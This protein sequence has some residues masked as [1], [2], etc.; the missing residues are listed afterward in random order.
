M[1]IYGNGQPGKGTTTG[2]DYPAYMPS[3]VVV[4]P[5]ASSSSSSG[6]SSLERIIN[7]G[8]PITG[9]NSGMSVNANAA[10]LS[11]LSGIASQ[12]F[13][14]NGLFDLIRENTNANNAWS[15]AQAQKQMD[16][17]TQANQIAME[18]NSL[19]A[20]KNRDW[21]KMMSDTA[22]QREIA[23]L[24]AAG[25][26]PVLSA[27]NG[28]GASTGSGATASGVTSAGAQADADQSAN[29]AM[30][31]IY[32]SIINAQTS[33]YNANLSAQTNLRMAEMQQQASM[34]G[35]Q[36]AAAASNYAA[37]QNY[38]AQ[39][40]G[41]DQSLLNQREQRDWNAQHPNSMWQTV[42]SDP[43]TKGAST[44]FDWASGLINSAKQ[45]IQKS[46]S[47]HG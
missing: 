26:N 20:A 44:V 14:F 3:S 7:S 28:N 21:Q 41:A 1:S 40:Y 11:G 6:S 19:E 31:A 29:T 32:G 43:V 10:N 47:T 45:K 37:G 17:Q 27:M 38:A 42:A 33:M 25:L 18:F 22:H 34:Y 5:S 46:S 12:G 36:M 15:A 35:A 23:D 24:K 4:M 39:I 13:D 16:F 9:G 30:A 2:A 8:V